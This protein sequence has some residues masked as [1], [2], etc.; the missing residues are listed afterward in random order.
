[1]KVH[2]EEIALTATQPVLV[3]KIAQTSFDAPLHYH[4]AYELT[5]IEEGTGNRFLGNSIERY[6]NNDFILV[7]SNVPHFWESDLAVHESLVKATVIQIEPRWLHQIVDLLP[8]TGAIKALFQESMRGISWSNFNPT[9][10]HELCEK[11]GLA[12]I[13]SLFQF[14]ESLAYTPYQT[15]STG[16]ATAQELDSERLQGILQYIASRFEEKITLQEVA[17]AAH[18]SVPSFCRFFKQQTNKT[19]VSYLTEVRITQAKRGLVT[20]EAPI[21]EIAYQ[22][23]FENLSHFHRC[24]QQDAQCTP[25]QYRRAY[26]KR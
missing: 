3:R 22:V 14:L 15:L 11:Q 18:L 5:W 6:E 1:M 16:G 8:E 17:E 21:K 25:A 13:T 19:F 2:L 7:G 10:L 24:F 20:T 4:P 23:G 26:R 9:L 12:F